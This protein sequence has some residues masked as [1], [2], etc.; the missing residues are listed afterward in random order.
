MTGLV[1][2]WAWTKDDVI[3]HVLPLHHVHGVVN[4]L[5]CPLW[6]GAT[7]VMLPEFSAQLVSRGRA[8][9]VAGSGPPRA[10]SLLW[11][12]ESQRRVSCYCWSR[13]S[14]LGLRTAPSVYS[15]FWKSK[16]KMRLAGLR[17][18]RRRPDSL[19]RLRGRICSCLLQ[20][21]EAPVCPALWLRHANL[22][23]C[24]LVAAASSVARSPSA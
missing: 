11:G 3:L 8:L 21:L 14:P 9:G 10:R 7:C 18:R 17:A 2:K 12:A 4:K 19:W 13:G 22:C 6:V 20:R 5:L 23:F 1:R 24:V 15:Q 16:S